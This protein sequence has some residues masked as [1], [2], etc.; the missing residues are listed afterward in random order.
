[1]P[2]KPQKARILLKQNKAEVVK[3]TPFT[4]QLTKAT[5]EAKQPIILG[6]D[7][8]YN[9]IGL[10]AVTN[11]AELYAVEIMLR[12]DIVKLLSECRMYRRN[13]RNKLW[14]RPARWQN[15]RRPEGWLTPSIQHKFDT[16]LKAIANVCKILPVT[17]I[18]VEVGNFDVQKIKNPDISGVEYQKGKQLNFYNIREYIF[19]RDSH[20]C[21]HCK[22]K[23]KDNILN[24]HH[25]ISR[26]TGGDRP[27]NLITLCKTCHNKLHRGEIKLKAKI[28]KGYKAETFM[29]AVRWKLINTLKEQY[30]NVYHTYGYITKHNR[31]KHDISKSHINDA[32]VI[33][34]GSNQDRTCRYLIKQVRKQNRKL[35]KGARSHIKN[36]APRYIKGF[37]R[38][39]KVLYNGQECFIFGRRSTGYFDLRKLDGTKIH[40]SANYKKLKLLERATTLLIERKEV[41]HS[42]SPTRG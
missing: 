28:S 5:G 9:Y 20:K 26:Q 40:A 33:A 36:T 38:Y 31:I 7:S 32:F 8:G 29:S 1:M 25:L 21:Q 19:H 42:S 34:G 3:L 17:K 12:T 15:R 13:R 2:C 11:I 39:D 6:V 14:Y 16:H 35:H 30:S 4:I 41:C 22:G 23:S 37:K 24:V 10:S 27:D 18:V